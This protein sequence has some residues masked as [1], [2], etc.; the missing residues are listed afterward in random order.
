MTRPFILG[1][2][3][4]IGM[5]KSTTAALFAAASIPVWD[6]DAVVRQLYDL[7]GAAVAPIAAQFPNAVKDGKVDRKALKALLKDTPEAMVQ[8]EAI[9]HPLTAQSRTEFV[10]SHLQEPLIVLDIPLLFETG[11]D[12]VCDAVLVVSAPAEIQKQRVLS[13]GTMSEAEFELILS[14]QMPDAEKRARADYV[15][16]TL[17]VETAARDVRRLIDQIMEKPHA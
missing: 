6:A 3:G 17:D 15:I 2:T 1:L 4:S 8:L 13:R 10:A 16:E 12:K 9:V 5:G 11:A 14:K 7:G